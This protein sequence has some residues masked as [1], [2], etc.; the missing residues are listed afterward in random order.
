V[1]E[2]E[3]DPDVDAE[4]LSYASLVAIV[5]SRLDEDWRSVTG[6]MGQ[7]ET[8]VERDARRSRVAGRIVAAS[9]LAEDPPARDGALAEALQ[10]SRI[11]GSAPEYRLL[12]AACLLRAGA[13]DEAWALVRSVADEEPSSTSPPDST[14]VAEGEFRLANLAFAKSID[15]LGKF[16]P[17]AGEDL[18]PGNAILI[19]GEFHDGA[20]F[21]EE[22][23]NG[24][25]DRYRRSFSASLAV[26]SADGVEI[27]T[28]DFLPESRGSQ[29]SEG[30]TDPV[31]FWARYTIPADLAPGPYRVRIRGTD[32]LGDSEAS[33]EIPLV[34]RSATRKA[35]ARS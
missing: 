27:D 3:A 25:G 17:A 24:E 19:Y 22:G 1:Q 5:A 31:N 33:A 28:L 8:P 15:G 23:S 6:G 7:H 11:E 13:S 20:S 2:T 34:V 16:V 18:V 29:T 35:G 9:F 10:A 4:D 21:L 30:P 32:V 12:A 26:V 14:T